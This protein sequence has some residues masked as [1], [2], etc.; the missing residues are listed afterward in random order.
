MFESRRPH[1][2]FLSKLRSFHHA[3]D[4]GH[5][6]GR[7]DAVAMLD[8][9]ARGCVD[10]KKKD[11]VHQA[12]VPFDGRLPPLEGMPRHPLAVTAANFSAATAAAEV[13]RA[14]AALEAATR[15]WSA[16]SSVSVST[17]GAVSEF[18]M[19][20][21][22]AWAWGRMYEE[23]NER[24]ARQSAPAGQVE[25]PIKRRRRLAYQLQAARSRLLWLERITSNSSQKT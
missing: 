6:T 22:A 12:L 2:M 25:P 8:D 18:I 4:F 13:K 17:S 3:S 15:E 10:L 11:H 24:Q 23:P 14:Q 5:V 21:A 20:Q 7:P 9:C 19:D 1:R 16:S